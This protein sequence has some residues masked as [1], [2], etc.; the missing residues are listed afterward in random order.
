[1][2]KFMQKGIF[3]VL[4]MVGMLMIGMTAHAQEDVI[5]DGIYVGDVNISGMTAE[6]AKAAVQDYVDTMGQAELTLIAAQD[7][8]VVV[9]VSEFGITWANPQVVDEAITIGTTGNVIERY[10][11]QKDLEQDNLIYELELEYDAQAISD[12]LTGKC[13]VYDVARVDSTLVRKDKDFEITIGHTGYALDVETSIDKIYNF[14][15][16]E[17][18]S[19]PATDRKSVV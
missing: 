11:I 19:A 6:A 8:Q 1:M 3:T 12:V 14:L 10:K 5:K 4:V 13:A 16:T 15:E 9:K 2:K 17:W 18:Q 7:N